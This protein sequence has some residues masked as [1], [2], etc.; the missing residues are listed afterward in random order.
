MTEAAWFAGRLRELRESLSR[1]REVL[2][3]R[4][5]VPVSTILDLERGDKLPLE[6]GRPK[7]AE[8]ADVPKDAGT[9]KKRGGAK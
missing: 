7:K 3:E 5:R 1:T 2:F 6:R 9:G 8:L 4:S